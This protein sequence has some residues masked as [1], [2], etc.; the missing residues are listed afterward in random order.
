MISERFL[1][2]IIDH[3]R[4]SIAF[5][6]DSILTCMFTIFAADFVAAIAATDSPLLSLLNCVI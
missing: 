4:S 5:Y 6:E 1:G 2:D 3:L